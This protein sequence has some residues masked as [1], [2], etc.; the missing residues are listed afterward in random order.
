MRN[1]QNVLS[2]LLFVLMLT[3]CSSM[4]K[5][6]DP[7]VR[8][9]YAA[10]REYIAALARDQMQKQDVTGLSLALVDDQQVIWAEGF[11]YADAAAGIAAKPETV[12]RVGSISK[13][14]TATAAMQLSEQGLLDIDRPLTALLP[15]FAMKSRFPGA[16]PITP[17]HLMTHHSGLPSDLA[18]GMW[19]SKPKPFASLLP[20][21]RDEYLVAPPNTVYAYSN[22]GV[23]L[24]GLAMEN[25][26]GRDFPSIL[27]N[28]LLRPLGMANSWFSTRLDYYP[29]TAKA[30]RKGVATEEPSLR[31]VPAGG[32]NSTVLDLSRFISMVF[33]SGKAGERQIIKPATLAEMLRPQNTAVPLD[34]DFRTG[35]GWAL[36]GLGEIDIS[37]AGPVAHHS[38]A[39][40]NYRSMLLVLPEQK[41]GVVVLA[42]SD[43]AGSVVNRVA[44][45]AI[46]LALEVKS[47]IRQPRQQEP[48]QSATLPDAQLRSYEGRYASMAGMIQ[49]TDNSGYLST[50]LMGT[51]MHLIPRSD[52]MLG[53]HY[54]LLGLVPISLGDL[55]H[56]GIGRAAIDEQEIL[57][58][59]Y[60]GKDFLAA[61]PVRM[62]PVPTKWLDRTGEY[63]IINGNSDT[64]L[65]DRIRLHFDRGLLLIDFA[66]PLFFTG[67][68]SQ[69]IE[70][71]SENEAIIQG[72]GRGMGETIRVIQ[73]SA[74]ELLSYSGYLLKRK[75]E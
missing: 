42:N 55:D 69:A 72:Y 11:G 41:L 26:A 65:V 24:L 17:R 14:L 20:R 29:Q 1:L 35:L 8:G 63:E 67:T 51:T 52:G 10:V 18:S 49:L 33:A 3:G 36:S 21:L 39:T 34:L 6:P 15:T 68:M 48:L 27:E 23:T 57:K 13:L 2:C 46:K 37:N 28:S 47:G 56:V 43:T 40:I 16:P 74:G 19:G 22:L 61:V 50:E 9:D 71:L 62:V 54:R 58:V 32:L 64:M 59:R 31:D 60:H 45:E 30:Y 44:A 5:R 4:P 66:M 38:G 7:V 75:V 25:A 12:Y 73:G 53:L 70:P